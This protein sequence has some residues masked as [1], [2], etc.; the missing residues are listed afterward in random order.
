MEWSGYCE[1][2]KGRARELI[3]LIRAGNPSQEERDR[4]FALELAGQQG[5][6]VDGRAGDVD[7]GLGGGEGGGAGGGGSAVTQ[8]GDQQLDNLPFIQTSQDLTAPA[9]S[10]NP[11][12]TAT[13]TSIVYAAVPV[14]APSTS[15][16]IGGGGQQ[17]FINTNLE[18]TTKAV[19]NIGKSI[20][21]DILEMEVAAMGTDVSDSQAAD[22]KEICVRIKE[23]VLE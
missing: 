4:R 6:G 19:N 8:T 10:T 21:C 1:G 12:Q 7:G 13:S 5:R 2:L 14:P 11:G 3:A 15:T 20:D 9:V 18:L 22:I 16:G 23:Q 17:S